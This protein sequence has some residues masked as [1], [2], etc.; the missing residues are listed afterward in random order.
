M[1][2]KVRVLTTKMENLIFPLFRVLKR[3]QD[4]FSLHFTTGSGTS[5]ISDCEFNTVS[6]ALS[7]VTEA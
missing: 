6:G 1:L 4:A 2:H 3:N 5:S 7:D